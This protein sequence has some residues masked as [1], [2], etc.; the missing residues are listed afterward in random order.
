MTTFLFWNLKNKPLKDVIASIA[1]NYD[2]DILIFVEYSIEN[3][4]LLM[5]LNKNN[6]G[7]YFYA[8]GIGCNKIH[9]FARFNDNFIKPIYETDNLT[10]R[11]LVLP[12]L[13][14]ILIAITHF[15]SK[16]FWD[17]D[18]QS[19]ECIDLANS[20]KEAEMEVGHSRTILVG[21]FN[22]NPFETGL[23][24]AAGLHAVMSRKIAEKNKRIVQ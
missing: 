6:M 20:I 7:E 16:L 24:S 4:D 13:I 17:E 18:S 11:H 12:G 23:V 8:P 21:D 9:I 22:M 19:I 5:I 15:P 1:L 3:S 14:N 10:I 2:I